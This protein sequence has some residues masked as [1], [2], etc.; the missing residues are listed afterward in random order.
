MQHPYRLFDDRDDMTAVCVENQRLCAS[1]RLCLGTLHSGLSSTTLRVVSERKTYD[2]RLRSLHSLHQ[3]AACGGTSH[4]FTLCKILRFAPVLH[5]A[6]RC[7]LLHNALRFAT[8]I[9]QQR[10]CKIPLR[11]RGCLRGTLHIRRALCAISFEP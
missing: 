6:R 7:P 4:I 10:I 1:P 3:N 9:A 11:Q 2:M 5:N 8:D